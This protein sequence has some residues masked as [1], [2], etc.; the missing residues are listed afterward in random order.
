LFEGYDVVVS[1]GKKFGDIVM[2]TN[3]VTVK[4]IEVRYSRINQNDYI[5]LTDIAQFKNPKAP[6]DVVKNW[7]RSKETIAFLGLWEM[8]NNPNFKGVEFD[9]FKNEAGYNAFTLSPEQWIEKTG[10]IGI[11]TSRGR[12]SQGTFAHKDIAFE[13][14]S[15]VS[16]EFKLYFIYEFQRLKA[17][18]QKTLEWTAKRELAKVNYRIHTDA[19]KENLIVP[20]LSQ[21]Q[22]SFVYANEA[23]M[24]N[25]ALFGKTASQWRTKN[26]GK[27][28]NMRD[29]ASVE[30]LLVLANLESY[31]AILIEQGL[32]QAERIILLNKTARKQLE[33]LMNARIEYDRLLA[34]HKS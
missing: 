19:I 9:S 15:W 20:E 6:K 22:V 31:N 4:G 33:S 5:S 11:T 8:L 7:L 2:A 3:K 16:I 26:S 13:F 17:D 23:D 1:F 10:A 27:E 25:V 30:Q 12:Y 18:E 32:S 14:A 24:L 34:L 28:G 29:Y 21:K